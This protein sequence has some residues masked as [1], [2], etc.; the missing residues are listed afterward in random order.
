MKNYRTIA[1]AVLLVLAAVLRLWDFA[2]PWTDDHRGWGGSFYGNIARN[3]LKFGY[4][5]TKAAPVC[6]VNPPDSSHFLYY[7]NHPPMTGWLV[8]LSFRVLGYHTWAARLVAVLCSMGSLAF[9]FVMARKFWGTDAALIALAVAAAIPIAAFYGSYVD[10]Q[11]PI[12]MFFIMLTLYLYLRFNEAGTWG[13]FL[14]VLAA[15]FLAVLCDW[16]AYLLVPILAIHHFF[17][18]GGTEPAQKR[19][20]RILLLPLLACAMV[21]GFVLYCNWVRYGQASFNLDSMLANFRLR[22]F[23]GAVEGSERSYTLGDWFARIYD[24]LFLMYTL[25]VLLLAGLGLALYVFG[26]TSGRLRNGAGFLAVLF[27]FGVSY[28]LLFPQGAYVHDYWGYYAYPAV[29]IFATIPFQIMRR[30]AA[31]WRSAPQYAS[32]AAYLALI[33]VL[34][35]LATAGTLKLEALRGT[36]RYASNYNLAAIT[37][38]VSEDAFIVAEER[39]DHPM[40]MRIP[41]YLNNY[42]EFAAI[43]PANVQ[44]ANDLKRQVIFL[45]DS[46]IPPGSP[47]ANLHLAILEHCGIFMDTVVR[48]AAVQKLWPK[49]M[50]KTAPPTDVEAEYQNGRIEIRWEYPATAKVRSYNIYARSDAQIFYVGAQDFFYGLNGT[51]AYQGENEATVRV[52]LEQPIWIIVTAVDDKNNESG[53]DKPVRVEP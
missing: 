12:P 4:A 31:S 2:A 28:I 50:G 24:H 51:I 45:M 36:N 46:Y 41:F 18:R 11:G 1:L 15:F 44:V 43:C 23:S 53:F 16:P 40:N 9:F 29:A 14:L 42:V 38:S 22:S 48:G 30:T 6:S 49:I 32:Y 13:R 3:Y 25:P 8:S 39:L 26:I 47:K 21:A 27:V 52:K 10:V 5:E 35:A 20:W 33:G 34:C 7:L 19:K 17:S 37:H